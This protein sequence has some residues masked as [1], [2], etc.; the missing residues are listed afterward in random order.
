M[1]T[2]WTAIFLLLCFA[3]ARIVAADANN[4][5]TKTSATVVEKSGDYQIWGYTTYDTLSDGTIVPHVHHYTELATGMNYQ[6]N[7]E[8]VQSKEEILSQQGGGASATEGQYKVFFPSDIYQG[9]LQVTTPDGLQLQSRP[10]GI[11]YFDGTN[12]VLI[13]ELTNSVGQILPSGNQVIYTNAFT[14]INADLLCTYRRSKF[15]CDLVFHSQPSNPE[16]YGLN[17]QT[18]RLQLMT[19]FIDTPEPESLLATTN[20][21]GITDATLKFGAMAMGQGKAFSIDTATNSSKI[22]VSKTWAHLEGRTF[23][24]EEV[25]FRAI[26]PKLRN[27]PTQ[28]ENGQAGTTNSLVGRVSPSRL[29]PPTRLVQRSPKAIHMA[30]AKAGRNPGVVLDWVLYD[31]NTSYY[32]FKSDTTYYVSGEYEV[33][34]ATFEGG[35][36]IKYANN[37]SAQLDVGNVVC[38]SSL[39]RPI[40]LT[41]VDDNTVGERIDGSADSPS[42]YYG[43]TMLHVGGGVGDLDHFHVFYASTGMGVGRQVRNSQF[44]NCDTAIAT[45]GGDQWDLGGASVY[46][47]LMSVVNNGISGNYL[48]GGAVNLT[49]DQ[50]GTF[51]SDNADDW[52]DGV[53]VDGYSAYNCIFANTSNEA[54]NVNLDD[55]NNAEY[56][57]GFTCT[58]NPTTSP[59]TSAGIGNYYLSD[60]TLRSKDITNNV[61][62]KLLFDLQGLTTHAPSVLAST[63]ISSDTTLSSRV[64]LDTNPNPDLGYHYDPID[65]ISDLYSVNGAIL[66]VTNGVVIACL[67]EPGIKLLDGSSIVS[68]GTPNTPNWFIRCSSVQEESGSLGTANASSGQNISVNP[69][70]SVAPNGYFRFSKFAAPAG[71]GYHFNDSGGAYFS[72]LT[73]QDCEIMNGTNCFNGPASGNA[74][75]ALENNLFQRSPVYAAT[76]SGEVSLSF[77]NNLVLGSFVR[78]TEPSGNPWHAFNNDFDHCTISSSSAVANGFNAYVACTG[79]FSSSA[80]GDVSPTSVA[81]INGPLGEY[82]QP[83]SSPLVHV[84]STT[85]GGAGLYHYTTQTDQTKQ[86]NSTLDI[87]YHYVALGGSTTLPSG[88]VSLWHGEGNALDSYGG[89]NGTLVTN[90]TYGPGRFGQAFVGAGWN[91]YVAVGSAAN[92]DFQDFTIAAW[93]RKSNAWS[94]ALS[95]QWASIFGFWNGGYGFQMSEDGDLGLFLNGYYSSVNVYPRIQ[96]TDFHHIAVTKSGTTVVFYV[97]GKPYNLGWPYEYDVTFTNTHSAYIGG[98]PNDWADDFHGTIDELSIYNHG[99][100]PSEMHSLY[101]ATSAEGW[102]PVDTSSDGIPDYL[103]DANGDGAYDAGDIG[104]WKIVAPDTTDLVKLDTYTPLK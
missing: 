7:G 103:Q 56:S 71:C 40:T 30:Q 32:T 39:F 44:V 25:P 9:V 42:G 55:E 18:S 36:V 28:A 66:T 27:L 80:G 52:E 58:Y 23:L 35:T 61:D 89:N 26:A 72:S 62:I 98:Y 14:D 90:V 102:N 12:S 64:A 93:L 84:G 73:V 37:G 83:S 16:S 38:Q 47:V 3:N 13:A 53:N 95:S 31:W 57:S 82:Y 10:L 11:S 45:G 76:S 51:I 46:N 29:L 60:D 63:T 15:E 20:K 54:N 96:D 43:N 65:Y 94:V 59:F 77:S 21:L 69:T 1:K 33:D 34:T 92:L 41:A 75:V 2:L 97:D 101:Q 5:V 4:S 81:Y 86:A 50:C 24:I 91:S 48:S 85:G 70:D 74:T 19:E 68:F 67:N 99:L 78:L 6:Q 8:W 17:R 88:L 104:D 22:S 49:V 79:S 100:S 87:G